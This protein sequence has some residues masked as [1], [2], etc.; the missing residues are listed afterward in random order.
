MRRAPC[1]TTASTSLPI[2]TKLGIEPPIIKIQ[3]KTHEANIGADAVKAFYAMVHERDV[4][5]FIATSAFTSTAREFA[6]SKANLKLMTGVELI[7]LIQK[8]YDNLA[9]KYRQQIPLR[10]I[11]VPDTDLVPA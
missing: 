9:L 8:Y 10:R 1:A 2:A 11:L 5:I 4:G 7:E 6:R 3:V